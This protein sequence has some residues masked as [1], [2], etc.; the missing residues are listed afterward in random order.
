MNTA[1]AIRLAALRAVLNQRQK[2]P[3]ADSGYFQRHVMRWYS[4]KFFTPLDQVEQLPIEDILQAF[5]EER[6]E[7]MNDDELEAERVEALKTEEEKTREARLKDLEDYEAYETMKW[8]KEEEEAAIKKRAARK[9]AQQEQNGLRIQTPAVQTGLSAGLSKE[10]ELVPLSALKAAPP[11]I[12][13]SFVS[14]EELD[15]DADSL[16]ILAT[17]KPK[18]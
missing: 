5:Y 2:E 15:L 3:K 11:E 4:K 16:G 18:G 7:E 6:Y 12:S 17:P 8:A 9:K 14:E 10:T 1:H 13:M